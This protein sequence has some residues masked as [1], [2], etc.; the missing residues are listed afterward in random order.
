MDKAY[1][2]LTSALSPLMPL[3]LLLRE[4]KGKED[5]TRRHERFG[6]A[7]LKRPPG[8]LVWL[9]AASVGEANSVLLLIEK[10][11]TQFPALQILL[12]TGT[13]TSA[14]LMRK[15]LPGGVIHQY[16]PID[17]P[18][19]TERFIAHWLPDVALWVESEF[20]PN[21]VRAADEYQCFMGVI[22]ARMSERSFASW[23]KHPAF[24]HSML[25]RFNCVYAQSEGDASRLQ[26][27]GAKNVECLGNIKYDASLLPCDEAELA[28]LK[29]V[30][31]TRPVWLAASTHPGEEE[32]IMQTHMLLAATRPTL[33]TI[34]VPRHPE[35]GTDIAQ[36]VSK[37]ATVALRSR[38]ETLTANTAIYVADTLGELGL[39]YR[40]SER[41]FMGGSLVKQGGQN[42]L[43]PARLSCAVLTGPHT[44]NF[45]D[46][47]KD[48]ETA[49]ACLIAKS[50]ANLAAL[51]DSLFNTPATASQMQDRARCW[52]ESKGGATDKILASLTPILGWTPREKS[53]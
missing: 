10:I 12:T 49:K 1:R 17:T 30:I 51:L 8:R 24:I 32:Q 38:K 44:H 9:H 18:D 35:R 19:A 28:H 25:T 52:V 33:L 50:P 47:Y 36:S 6:I 13:V 14:R 7:T 20:W 45:S 34:I 37:Q 29:N 4:A 42:P 23:K 39:F 2:V 16:V 27:L 53:A 26:G 31:G 11:R 5:K 43:E 21:L 41:V 3:W 46:I 40:L 15:R 22:N 48:M